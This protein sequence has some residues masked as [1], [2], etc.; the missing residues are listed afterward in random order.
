MG[1]A[2]VHHRAG[3][4]MVSFGFRESFTNPGLKSAGTLD[5]PVQKLSPVIPKGGFARGICFF[6]DFGEEQIPCVA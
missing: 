6:I 3:Y 1:I 5:S 4:L 2:V